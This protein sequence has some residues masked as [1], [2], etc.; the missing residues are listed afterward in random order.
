MV[1]HKAHACTDITGF[2]LAGHLVEMC[3]SSGVD[4]EIDLSA[5]PVFAAVKGC[6]EQEIYSGAIENNQE[7]SMAWVHPPENANEKHLPILY[8]PQTSGGLMIS[9][10]PKAA[11]ELV[12]EMKQRGNTGCALIGR[13]VKK[14]DKS[15]DP[16]VII[17]SA[18]L[19]NFIGN[20]EV[21]SQGTTKMKTPKE[22]NP[23]PAPSE[24]PACCASPPGLETVDQAATSAATP[25]A[26]PHFMDFMAKAGEAG[27]MGART[28]R[29][30]W[31]ALSVGF[32]CEACLSSHL[33]GALKEGLDKQEIEEAANIGIAFGG[34]SAM[35][36]YREV[37]KKLKI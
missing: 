22:P 33:K 21:L 19:K 7:Y 34:C 20:G 4:A 10:P 27:R 3:R 6:V 35:L 16:K 26:L 5:L 9:L 29:L 23:A 32:R 14:Q 30:I 37:C 2:G 1:K 36:L 12:K 25:D 11:K 13:M 8:D 24:Q 15:A 17:K 18:E 28:N 31:I